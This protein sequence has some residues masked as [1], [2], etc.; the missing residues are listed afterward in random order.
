[1]GDVR[2]VFATAVIMSLL[3]VGFPG[4]GFPGVGFLGAAPAHAQ[5]AGDRQTGGTAYYTFARPG[6]NTIEVLVLGGQ[7]GVY[8]V[9]ENINLGQLLALSGSGGGDRRSRVKVLLF[10]RQQGTRTKIL[11]EEIDDFASRAAYPALRDGDVVR[12]ETRERLNWRDVLQVT[13][14]VTSL[15]VTLLTVFEVGRFD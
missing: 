9:G 12:I 7:A 3:G 5:A 6:Q 8:Q 14:S 4:V 15:A 11:E 13:T 1:M 2:F 10:R